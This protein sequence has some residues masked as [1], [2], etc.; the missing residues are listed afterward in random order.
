VNGSIQKN[1]KVE[2]HLPRILAGSY[3]L[4]VMLASG[5]FS[6]RPIM[7]FRTAAA[8]ANGN[9]VF[10]L[11]LIGWG[12]PSLTILAI[13]ISLAVSATWSTWYALRRIRFP[14]FTLIGMLL[15]RQMRPAR[16]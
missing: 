14:D 12:A 5:D 6:G 8:L 7:Q 2:S 1:N 9:L 13:E 3:G 15:K 4:A 10:A 11:Y 16:A